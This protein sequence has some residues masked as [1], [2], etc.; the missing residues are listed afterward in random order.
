[1]ESSEGHTSLNPAYHRAFTARQRSRS[2]PLA[3]GANT[4]H[5]RPAIS[6]SNSSITATSTPSK[7]R[8]A[9]S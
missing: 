1:M 5:P 8:F 2:Q 7:L 4:I 3:A 6:P 9:S